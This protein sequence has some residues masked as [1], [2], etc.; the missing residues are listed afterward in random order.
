MSFP[1]FKKNWIGIRKPDG[2]E[3]LGVVGSIF[4]E[5]ECKAKSIVVHNICKRR[6]RVGKENGK[7]FRYCPLCLVPIGNKED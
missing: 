6:A 7:V 3:D 1:K 4:N 5:P 2:W